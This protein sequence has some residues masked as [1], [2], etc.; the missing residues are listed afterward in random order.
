MFW[1]YQVGVGGDYRLEILVDHYQN[2]SHL[3]ADGDCCN[4]DTRQHLC[5]PCHNRFTFCLLKFDTVTKPGGFGFY[6]FD[7]YVCDSRHHYATGVVGSA[8]DPDDMQFAENGYI[9][10]QNNIQNPLVFAGNGSWPV[11]DF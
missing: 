3:Q 5:M 8:Q 11:S 2:P 9:D 1:H 4:W 7:T 10:E 6:D